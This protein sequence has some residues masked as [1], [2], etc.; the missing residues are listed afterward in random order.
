MRLLYANHGSK[1]DLLATIQSIEDDAQ[2]TIDHYAQ[3]ATEYARGDGLFPD[4]IHV[5]ALLASLS[6]EQ[7]RATVRWAQRT[8]GTVEA[9]KTTKT[10]DIEWATKT[11]LNAAR[12]PQND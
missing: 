10:P 8:R 9:W 7:A 11:L 5:N 1:D 3:L 4:R 12:Q 6:I 2:S